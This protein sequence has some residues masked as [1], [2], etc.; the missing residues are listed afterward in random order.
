MWSRPFA[1]PGHSRTAEG[2]EREKRRF[3]DVSTLNK[4]DSFVGMIV[5]GLVVISFTVLIVA[6]V[7]QV[8]TRFVLNNALSWT[9]ELARY[10]FIWANLTGA[11]ICVQ[12]ASHATVTAITDILPRRAQVVL[13]LVVQVLVV[14]ICCVLVVQGGKVT[15][16][17]R[18]QTSPALHV[19]MALINASVPVSAFCM[20]IHSVSHFAQYILELMGRGGD[21][22]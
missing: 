14:A 1:V 20:L 12:H 13:K 2:R 5:K 8:F 15:Y 3:S 17:T 21:E 19:N 4:V 18:F 11:A 16:A 7:L 9:E 22:K 10:A 6:C